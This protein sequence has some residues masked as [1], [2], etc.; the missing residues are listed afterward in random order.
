MPAT[1][2]DCYEAGHRKFSRRKKNLWTKRKRTSMSCGRHSNNN[3][4]ITLHAM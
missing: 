2:N 1:I 4:S 3:Y